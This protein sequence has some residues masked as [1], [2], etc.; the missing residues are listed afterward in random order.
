MVNLRKQFPVDGQPGIVDVATISMNADEGSAHLG[1]Q[2]L[3]ETDG[4]IVIGSLVRREMFEKA[5]DVCRQTKEELRSLGL[6][7][8]VFLFGITVD[9]QGITQRSVTSEEAHATA[10][11]LQIEYRE[12]QFT[13]WNLLPL[14]ELLRDMVRTLWEIAEVYIREVG[15]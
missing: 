5:T 3:K 1:V 11:S 9:Y 14:N 2:A 12:A 13:Y 10:L 6:D 4:V 7:S 8:P 15:S